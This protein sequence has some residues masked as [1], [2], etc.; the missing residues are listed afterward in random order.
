[1]LDRC[2][3]FQFVNPELLQNERHSRLDQILP[4]RVMGKRLYDFTARVERVELRIERKARIVGRE[5]ISRI[6]FLAVGP[7]QVRADIEFPL[8][9]IRVMRIPINIRLGIIHRSVRG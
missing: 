2:L 7:H 3:K 8:R 4:A 1:M 6:D 5:D 9:V